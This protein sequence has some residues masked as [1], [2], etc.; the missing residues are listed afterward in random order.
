VPLDLEDDAMGPLGI[1]PKLSTIPQLLGGE[2]VRPMPCSLLFT[3]EMVC[4]QW[5]RHLTLKGLRFLFKLLV[6]FTRGIRRTLAQ[7]TP[8]SRIRRKRQVLFYEC[9]LGFAQCKAES[10]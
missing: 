8:I 9:S 3:N 2:V 7:P 4:H 6:L 5:Q 10:F 1:I